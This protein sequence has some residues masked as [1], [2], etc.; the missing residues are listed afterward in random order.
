M[1]LRWKLATAHW[2]RLVVHGLAYRGKRTLWPSRHTRAAARRSLGAGFLHLSNLETPNEF[3]EGDSAR[4]SRLKTANEGT[5][6][7]R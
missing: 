1:P 2:N 7:G 3:I 4:G 5:G 6:V